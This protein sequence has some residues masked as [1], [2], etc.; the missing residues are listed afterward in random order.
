MTLRL[1]CNENVPRIT[2]ETLRA[3]GHDV[4]WIRTDAPGIPDIEVLAKARSEE[5]ICVTFDKDFGELAAHSPMPA[6]CGVVLLRLSLHLPDGAVRA[7]MLIDA[8]R[9][10]AGCFSVIDERRTRMRKLAPSS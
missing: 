2:V 6:G 4:T 8:R 7:A 10:W 5:R 1:L 3:Q 9:D